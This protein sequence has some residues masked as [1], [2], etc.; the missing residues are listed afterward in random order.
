MAR[1]Q[2]DNPHAVITPPRGKSG[3]RGR[4]I[5]RDIGANKEASCAEARDIARAL[6]AGFPVRDWR[7]LVV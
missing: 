3:I 1:R 7:S 2:S 4:D 5:C 6:R